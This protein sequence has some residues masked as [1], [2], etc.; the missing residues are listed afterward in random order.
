MSFPGTY[1]IRYYYGDTLEFRV[2]PKNTS[3]EPFDLTTFTNARF[4]LAPNR[5]TPSEDH[6][7]CYAQISPDKT[8]VFC[9]IRPEDSDNLNPATQYVYDIEIFKAAQPYDVTYTLLTGNVSITNDVTRPTTGEIVPLPNNPTDLEIGTITTTS[10]DVSWT[11]PEGGGALTLY[12]LAAIPYTTDNGLI[13]DAIGSST[14]TVTADNTSYTFTSLSSNTAYSLIVIGSGPSGDASLTT[15]LTNENSVSTLQVITT[16]QA[17]T[18]TGVTPLNSSLQVSFTPGNNGGTA[19]T[20]Y[21]YSID[22]TAF[23][24]FDPETTTSPLLIP[25]LI[26]GTAYPISIKAINAQ[27]SSPASNTISG[28]PISV[29]E[30]P[31][32]DSIVPGDGDAE[33][34]FTAGSDNGSAITNYSYSLDG[35]NYTDF[36]PEQTTSPLVIPGIEPDS[37]LD[38]TI[39]SINSVGMSPASNSVE[40]NNILVDFYVTNDGSGAYI[41][42]GGPN[43]TITLTRGQTYIFEIDAVGHPFWIQTVAPPYSAQDVYNEGI[44][45]IGTD[46]GFITWTVGESTPSTLYYVCQFHSAMG[47]T[48]EIFDPES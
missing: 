31:V 16:P 29:P 21:S 7:V 47:G 25:N 28:T 38:V 2:F 37:V 48:I 30:A 6:I 32:I 42:A 46:S 14:T 18:I 17:P 44:S 22:G 5:T 34:F 4:T 15:L 13:E 45:N 10:I 3:G 23:M 39:K 12:K 33:V 8:N 43:S 36:S 1:N 9:A 41:I 11:A 35:I 40:L 24:E 19:I 26:N 20:N 27:G